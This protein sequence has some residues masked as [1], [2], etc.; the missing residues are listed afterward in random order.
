MSRSSSQIA[1]DVLTKLAAE[2]DAYGNLIP[3]KIPAVP[4]GLGAILGGTAA[5][6]APTERA[7]EFRELAEKVPSNVE[8]YRGGFREGNRS[9]RFEAPPEIV[10]KFYRNQALRANA[11]R[12]LGGVGA[13]ALTGYGLSR[14][15]GSDD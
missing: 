9:T 12:M 6:L 14:L 1:V 7:R 5:H 15:L 8:S 10:K 2:Y 4:M 11:L 3:P 13:G